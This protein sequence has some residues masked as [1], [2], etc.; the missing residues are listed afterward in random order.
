MYREKSILMQIII[1]AQ[2]V[3]GKSAQ[4]VGTKKTTIT[5]VGIT[6]RLTIGN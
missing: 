2:A 3:Y 1:K 4:N 6:H 5:T